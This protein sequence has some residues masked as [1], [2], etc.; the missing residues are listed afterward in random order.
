MSPVA[1][2]WCTGAGVALILLVLG[3]AFEALFHPAGRMVLS[4]GIMRRFTERDDRFSLP[5][6]MPWLLEMTDCSLSP[7]VPAATRLRAR[8][9]RVAIDDF[10]RTTAMRFHREDAGSAAEL[11]AR[12]AHDHLRDPTVTP[13][14]V[15]AATA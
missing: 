6:V 2:V 14:P 13:P 7:D 1:A 5:A 12:D 9:L 4:R 15:P 8:M 3:D 10:A 11:L